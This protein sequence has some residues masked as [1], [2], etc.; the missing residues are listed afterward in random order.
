VHESLLETNFNSRQLL[1][2]YYVENASFLKLDNIS[3]GYT[4]SFKE[5]SSLRVYSTLS[6][7]FTITGYSGQNPEVNNG[8][9]NNLYPFSRTML[10]GVSLNF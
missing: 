8:I 3:I 5:T 10:F 1:S 7:I 6:N 2:D 4:M 9:D